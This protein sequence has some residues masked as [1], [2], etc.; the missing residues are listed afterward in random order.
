MGRGRVRGVAEREMMDGEGMASECRTTTIRPRV[1]RLYLHNNKYLL[2]SFFSFFSLPFNMTHDSYKVRGITIENERRTSNGRRGKGA[3]GRRWILYL[4]GI[5]IRDFR[6]MA[7]YILIKKR[8]K[9]CK[10]KVSRRVGDC[11]IVV[12]TRLLTCLVLMEVDARVGRVW[13]DQCTRFQRTLPT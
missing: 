2:S 4:Q 10:V 3:G 7:K 1:E 11:S 8:G 13:P 12:G 9:R 5:A 6:G